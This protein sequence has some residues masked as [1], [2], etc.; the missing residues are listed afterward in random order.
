MLDCDV[1]N[2]E[3]SRSGSELL[4]AFM[5]GGFRAALGPGVYDTHSPRIPS[6][7]EIKQRV[8]SSL[9]KIPLEKL[10]VNPDC[11]LKTRGWPETRNAL[12]A[13]VAAA[14]QL[15]AQQAQAA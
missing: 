2:F 1:L 7:S 14:R 4:S 12:E 5:D 9:E 8:S 3:D 13:M 6:V 11:G 10:W 15:R